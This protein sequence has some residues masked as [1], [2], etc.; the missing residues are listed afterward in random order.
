[1]L[2]VLFT[3][4]LLFVK[5]ASSPD[6]LLAAVEED[7]CWATEQVAPVASFVSDV[8]EVSF[9]GSGGICDEVGVLF[10]QYRMVASQLFISFASLAS[11]TYS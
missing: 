6:A 5:E 9:K 2:F 1:M 10:I 11:M 7:G 3:L 4:L 8:L